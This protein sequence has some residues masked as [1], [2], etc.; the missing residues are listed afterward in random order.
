FG[1]DHF[2]RRPLGVRIRNDL[3]KYLDQ[4]AWPLDSSGQLGSGRIGASADYSQLRRPITQPV[5]GTLDGQP[6]LLSVVF[7][8]D[9]Y[10]LGQLGWCGLRSEH[11]VLRTVAGRGLSIRDSIIDLVRDANGVAGRQ[12]MN[13]AANF[14][15]ARQHAVRQQV[16]RVLAEVEDFIV[17]L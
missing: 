8:V 4:I 12:V 11:Q 9:A 1:R 15:L 17:P 10:A 6:D 14:I 16:L 3:C 7:S 2:L 5:T 13:G